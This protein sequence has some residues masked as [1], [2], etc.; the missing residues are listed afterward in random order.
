MLVR[1]LAVGFAVGG[2]T[3]SIADYRVN[4]SKTSPPK[5]G[6]ESRTIAGYYIKMLVKSY[7][8]L[9]KIF[10]LVSHRVIQDSREPASC[11]SRKLVN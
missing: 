7:R 5:C 2:E 11:D 8:G 4:A 1:T 9:G 3:R 6:S 10:I